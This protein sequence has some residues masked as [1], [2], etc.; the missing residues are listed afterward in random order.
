MLLSALSFW[1]LSGT[2]DQTNNW[3]GITAAQRTAIKADYNNAGIRL[4]V[5][6]LDYTDTAVPSGANPTM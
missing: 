4:V 6:V 5:S 2:A 3:A 1:P